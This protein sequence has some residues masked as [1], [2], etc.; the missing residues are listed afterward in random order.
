MGVTVSP[1]DSKRDRSRFIAFPYTLFAGVEEWVP[2]LRM[3][4]RHTLSPKRNPFFEHGSMQLFLAHEENRI[5]GRIAAIINGKHLKKYGDSTGFFGFFDCVER[6]DVAEALLTAAG[7]WLREQG[8][9]RWRGPANP[10][11]NDVAGLLVDGFQ[12]PPAV[13][14]PYNLPYYKT[15]VERFGFS[16]AMTMYSYFLHRKYVTMDRSIRG[17]KIILRRNPDLRLRTMDMKRFLE[18]AR[19]ILDVYND[20]WSDN[21]GNVAMTEGEFEK[22]A[23]D[24]K[25]VLD[26]DLVFILEK[27]EREVGFLVSLPD[28]NVLLQK[29]RS[30]RL[31]PFGLARMLLREKVAPLRELRVPLMGVRKEFHGRGFD[32]VLISAVIESG[33]EKGYQSAEMSW[34]L[35]SNPAM[36][37]AAEGVGGTRDKEYA[38]YE[39]SLL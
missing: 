15:F 5:V 31:F 18:D 6:Y 10:T 4:Q 21:W 9:T 25:P 34:V 29:N 37:N 3:D 26:P 20:A 19:L 35:A 13:F 30:G 12:H 36:I 33:W 32:A 27:G 17:R 16:R 23:N 1:V 2:P 7:N 11:M 22:L 14:M 39:A 38:L 24:M 8:L 28:V